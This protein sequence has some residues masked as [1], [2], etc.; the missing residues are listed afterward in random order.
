[1][2]VEVGSQWAEESVQCPAELGQGLPSDP[3]SETMINKY[4]SITPKDRAGSNT[5]SSERRSNL[6]DISR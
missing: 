4:K 3:D 5:C 1:M 2:K 6:P